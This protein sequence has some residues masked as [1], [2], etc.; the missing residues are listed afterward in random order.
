M[1][2]LP[3]LPK[4]ELLSYRPFAQLPSQHAIGAGGLGFKSW[5][6]QIATVSPATRHSYDVSSELC[7]PGAKPRRWAPQLVTRFGVI[8]RVD[9]NE[10]LFD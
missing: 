3:I 9:Y 8:P 10:D 1:P 7:C 2:N 4:K 5:V 6:D